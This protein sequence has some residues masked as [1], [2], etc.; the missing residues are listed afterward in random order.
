V[1]RHIGQL[2]LRWAYRR[3]DE[4]VSPVSH[5]VLFWFFLTAAACLFAAAVL[6]PVWEEYQETLAIRRT[7]RQRLDVLRQELTCRQRVARAL[8]EDPVVN[9]H[10][11]LREL[12]YHILGQEV[13]KTQP[14]TIVPT[15]PPV[16]ASKPPMHP[17]LRHLSGL[18][19]V[20]DRW[21]RMETWSEMLRRSDIRRGMLLAAAF[22]VAVALVVFAPPAPGG[23]AERIF[24]PLRGARRDE[25]VDPLP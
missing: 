20:P 14:E 23:L 22:L 4:Q 12:N 18:S 15:S 16:R 11:A 8:E 1:D 17:V 19:F 10:T 21:L 9:E 25:P 13:I 6:V 2:V 24:R 7:A 3:S 5:V